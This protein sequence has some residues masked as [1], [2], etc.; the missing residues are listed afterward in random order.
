MHS[1]QED[2]TRQLGQ[3]QKNLHVKNLKVTIFFI[4]M[5]KK[6]IPLRLGNLTFLLKN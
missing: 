2:L 3:E 1:R 4:A 5:Y 6:G